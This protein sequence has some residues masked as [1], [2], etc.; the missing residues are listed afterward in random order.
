MGGISEIPFPSTGKGRD[1]GDYVAFSNSPSK[2]GENRN[3]QKSVVRFGFEIGLA[4]FTLAVQNGV[5]R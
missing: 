2:R 3:V 5:Q 4:L 1:R